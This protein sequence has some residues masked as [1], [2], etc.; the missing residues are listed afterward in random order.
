MRTR[1]GACDP[2]QNGHELDIS[3]LHPFEPDCH[4]K[5]CSSRHPDELAFNPVERAV[6][7]RAIQNRI[8]LGY[9]IDY[10]LSERF[11]VRSSKARLRQKLGFIVFLLENEQVLG[12]LGFG[13]DETFHAVAVHTWS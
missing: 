3:I 9:K 11:G 5:K 1:S 4:D 8:V 7:S 6:L 12:Q 10:G 2:P 13:D